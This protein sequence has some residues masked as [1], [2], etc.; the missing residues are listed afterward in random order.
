MLSKPKTHKARRL[1]AGMPP[2]VGEEN[3][4]RVLVVVSIVRWTP[5]YYHN[6][7]VHEIATARNEW[8]QSWVAMCGEERLTLVVCVVELPLL[9]SGICNHR[10]TTIDS[11]T[12]QIAPYLQRVWAVFRAAAGPFVPPKSLTSCPSRMVERGARDSIFQAWTTPLCIVPEAP[13]H[14]S[15]LVYFRSNLHPDGHGF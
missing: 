11:D 14:I 12:G 6:Q 7:R 15:A 9:P 10:Q 5:H 3:F 4:L 13:Q 8:V 2:R 1:P